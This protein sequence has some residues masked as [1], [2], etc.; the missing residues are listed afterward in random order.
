MIKKILFVDDEVQILRSLNRIFVGSDFDIVLAQSGSEALDI[1]EHEPIGLIVSDMRMPYMNGHELLQTVR[2]KYPLTMR[3]ILSGYAQEK[4]IFRALQDGSAMLYL[5]KP[6]DNDQLKGIITRLFSAAELLHNEKLLVF[7]NSLASLPTLSSIYNQLWD[8]IAHD[9]DLKQIA[10]VIEEDPA[11]AAKILHIVN[12]A[13]YSVR[14]GSIW[15]AVTYLGLSNLR[16]IILSTLVLES[17]QEQQGCLDNAVVWQHASLTNKLTTAIYSQLLQ[18]KIPDDAAT[19]G[20]L[21]NVGRILLMSACQA[22]EEE[23]KNGIA[24]RLSTA[25]AAEC[26]HLGFSH[27]EAGGYLLN[28]W[29]L[30]QSL[31][32][33]A[34]FHHIPLASQVSD[35]KLLSVVHIARYHAWR[36]LDS[37]EVP[38]LDEHCFVFLGIDAAECQI[39]SDSVGNDFNR[40]CCV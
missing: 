21:H 22:D 30:P 4:E 39:L 17:E 33:V 11:T 18:E 34:L 7:A 38:V 13:F 9:A 5:L 32:E 35:K 36:L 3:V 31:V 37:A 2:A 14:T 26:S 28:L 12:S 6:W 20:L 15:K 1:L 29:G 10:A 23:I 19:A 40:R 16:S 25:Y 8:L 27:Q 24:C